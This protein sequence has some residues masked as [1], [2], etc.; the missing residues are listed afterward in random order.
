MAMGKPKAKLGK[1]DEAVRQILEMLQCEQYGPGARIPPE[2]ELVKQLGCCRST[3]RE[4]I[5]LLVSDNRLYRIRGSGTYVTELKR[6]RHTIAAILPDLFN[7]S[8]NRYTM[9]IGPPIIT[10][11]VNEAR[12][13][14]ANIILYSYGCD[15]S[16]LERDNIEDAVER[17]VDGIV[18]L[19]IGAQYN[20]DCLEHVKAAGI[21]LVFV[22]RYIEHFD[23]DYV[24]TDNYGGVFDAVNA[25]NKV[26]VE[27]I[28]YVTTSESVSSAGDRMMGYTAAVNAL[29]LPCNI[30]I[31]HMDQI[32]SRLVRTGEIDRESSE[33]ISLKKTIEGMKLPAALFSI[34][35][36]S[37]AFV[38][39]VLKDLQMPNDQ[40]ILGHFDSNPPD[41]IV[42]RCYFE[43]DQPF[44]EIGARAVQI[45]ASKIAGNTERQKIVLKPK[46]TIHNLSCFAGANVREETIVVK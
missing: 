2:S 41:K 17:G 30:I 6:S 36:M 19:Y 34:N 46:L 44:T 25:I 29:G 37:N 35:P 42:D 1:R 4:A 45:I 15:E 20:L 9:D 21:P 32:V 8:Y 18:I 13:H 11:M 39:E 38:Y 40:V 28:Y 16:K 27:N 10:A 23:S 3:V 14:S 7:E 12:K 26:G 33:Y 24:V 22:D 43:V 31:S 5:S